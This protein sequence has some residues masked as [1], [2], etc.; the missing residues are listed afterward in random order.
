MNFSSHIKSHRERLRVCITLSKNEMLSE[1]SDCL[2]Q[3]K[4]LLKTEK[5]DFYIAQFE[6]L[7]IEDFATTKYAVEYVQSFLAENELHITNSRQDLLDEIS[8]TSQNLLTYTVD[9]CCW[10][11]TE[12]HWYYCMEGEFAY[13]KSGMGVIIVPD[14]KQITGVSRVAKISELPSEFHINLI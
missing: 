7:K 1:L 3:A 11:Q 14:G 12:Y 8:I 10:M 6:V 4:S 13:K 9:D 2:A 5:L